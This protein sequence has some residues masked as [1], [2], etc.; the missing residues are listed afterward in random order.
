MSKDPINPEKLTNA[1]LGGRLD[2]EEIREY[3]DRNCPTDDF[4]DDELNHVAECCHHI[5]L[6]HIGALPDVGHFLAA[7]LKNNLF[8]AVNRADDT[9]VK[10]L[11]LY[12]IFLHN[13][14]PGTWRAKAKVEL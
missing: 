11:K 6:W 2:A 10:A 3:L 5:Y 9:N 12:V 1:W 13:V 7:V 14:A 4:S 8:E